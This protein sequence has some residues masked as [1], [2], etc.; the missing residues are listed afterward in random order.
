ME[1]IVPWCCDVPYHS[2]CLW[3]VLWEDALVH[4]TLSLI[5]STPRIHAASPLYLFLDLPLVYFATKQSW[6]GL[7]FATMQFSI[8]LHP[9]Q[10][11][12]D[13]LPAWALQIKPCFIPVMPSF[14]QLDR[15]TTEVESAATWWRQRRSKFSRV[16]P[17]LTLVP[18]RCCLLVVKVFIYHVRMGGDASLSNCISRLSGEYMIIFSSLSSLCTWICFQKHVYF[19]P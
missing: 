3:P 13:P 7:H 12:R 4:R 18:R 9:V 5:S 8:G 15:L 11:R 10:Y 17:V 2:K 14:I 6:I 16:K 19:L 1:S